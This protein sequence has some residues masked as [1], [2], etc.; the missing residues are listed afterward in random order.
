MVFGDVQQMKTKPMLYQDSC[1]SEIRGAVE[2][3]LA[4]NY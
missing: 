2:H 1:F 4:L 3:L